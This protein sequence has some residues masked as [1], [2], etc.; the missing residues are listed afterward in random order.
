MWQKGLKLIIFLVFL[1]S[2]TSCTDDDVLQPEDS[3]T[4]DFQSSSVSVG[5]LHNEI[6]SAFAGERNLF[7]GKMNQT[8]FISLFIKSANKVLKRHCIDFS[9]DAGFVQAKIAEFEKFREKCGYDFFNPG[10]DPERAFCYLEKHGVIS[11]ERIE[12]LRRCWKNIKELGSSSV[13]SPSLVSQEAV[14]I[15][16]SPEVDVMEHSAEWW[17]EY[18]TSMDEYVDDH[19]ELQGWWDRW[20]KRIRECCLVASDALGGFAASGGGPGTAA[21]GC[22][23]GSIMFSMAWQ[24]Y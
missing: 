11:P 8:E 7:L 3:S 9:V 6:M 20:K 24:P 16:I 18:Y 2:L 19:P 21:V 22:A 1:L 5:E 13:S 15:I 10:S 4:G 17:N 12:N 14:P 23:L